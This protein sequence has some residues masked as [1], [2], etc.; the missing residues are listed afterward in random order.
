[1]LFGRLRVQENAACTTSRSAD[2]YLANLS[3]LTKL[4]VKHAMLQAD[5][6]S[7]TQSCRP[8]IGLPKPPGMR[9]VLEDGMRPCRRQQD[10]ESDTGA[11]QQRMD[12]LEAEE[13]EL[14]G[15]V[16]EREAEMKA[17][18][19]EISEG[20]KQK[21]EMPELMALVLLAQDRASQDAAVP[22]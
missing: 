3:A 4:I 12:A 2:L 20:W 11:V 18:Q 14:Q 10:R 9:H 6:N 5:S 13:G 7:F 17:L 19:V 8:S 22:T 21:K 1:M 16:K 15:A